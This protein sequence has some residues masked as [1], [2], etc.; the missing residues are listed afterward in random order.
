MGKKRVKKKMSNKKFAAIWTVALALVLALAVAVNI[1]TSIFKGYVDL[2]L[3]GGD[4]II[5]KTEGSEDWESEYYTLDYE[6]TQ[7]V[8][9]AADALV[10]EIE[11]EGIVL[12]KNNGALPLATPAKVTLLGRDAADPVYGGSGSGSVDLSS[13]VDLR[14]GLEQAGYEINDTVYAILS[15]YASYKEELT[16]LG[17]SRVYDHPK[18]IITMDDPSTSTYYIGE[19][20]VENYTADAIS[21]FSSYGDAAIVVIGRGGG[22]GGDLTQDME[23]WDDNYMDGQHQLELNQDEKDMLALAEEHFDKVIVLINAS[24]SMEL[25]VLEDDEN[26]DAILWVGSPGQTGFNAVGDVL[27]GAVNPSGRTV[28]IYPA[29]F[30]QDPTFVNFGHYQYENISASNVSGVGTFVQYEEG[31]YVGYRYYETAAVEGFIDYDEAVV[32][33]FGYGLSYTTFDWAISNQELGG[34]DGNITVEVTVTNTGSV[35]GKDVVELYYSAPYYA[36]RGIEKSSVVLGAFAKTGVIEPGQSET[37]TLTL[38]VEDMASYDYKTE[39]VYVLDEGEYLITLQTDS[40]TVKEGCEPISYTVSG[41]QVYSGDNHRASDYSAVTNQFDDVSAMFTDTPT[42]GYALNMSRSDFAG[43][44]PTAPTGA[45]MT[46]SDAVIEGYQVYKAADHEDPEAEEPTTGADN[47]LSLIDL[48]GLPYDDPS[49]DLLLDQLEEKDMVKLVLNGMYATVE[50]SSIGKPATEDYDGPAG[51]NSYMTSLSCTSYPSEVVIASTWNADLAY[52]MGVMV[53]NEAIDNGVTG[54]YAPAMNIHR[55]PFGGRNFEYYSEDPFL[56]GVMGAATVS[57]ASSK[58]VY[59]TIKHFA[60]NDQETNRVNNGVSSWVNEQ[61]MREIYLKPFEYTVKNAKQTVNY[62]SD[63]L[64]TM[65][66]QEMAGCTAV[67]SSYNRLGAT[68]AGGSEALMQTVLRDEWG[69]EGL[70]ITDFDLYEYMYPDQA[71]A[72]GTDLILSTDAMKSMEDTSSPTALNNL[73][74]SC[75]N[76]LYAV[77]HSNA[78][79]GIVPGT[80]ISYTAAPWESG[81][82]IANCV[83]AVLLAAGVIWMIVR[84]KRNK[85]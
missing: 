71:I 31:I 62:I 72:A 14:A 65:S 42:E 28:D 41:K 11:S 50:M 19:M 9:A 6:S 35:A 85:T 2:Y 59:C 30:T 73:R 22:E 68:W 82:M 80:I 17:A 13:V 63:E 32:Y 25:G 3:G 29:D 23:G 8:Q 83:V 67:M 61:A 26:V 52:R 74:K 75:H 46:A 18:G 39:K 81:L 56:S 33:P 27:S 54:W 44:F 20:P 48:R 70:A 43:T 66:Q 15:S 12:L 55:S 47:G 58:G 77:V 4:I 7:D 24:T 38:A 36:D 69:F 79:N 34:V 37:V 64:G 1:L 57:G 40:H 76:I 5:T 49:W 84:I 60:V 53:G 51:I 16:A 21:S 10:E 78:M 45:D